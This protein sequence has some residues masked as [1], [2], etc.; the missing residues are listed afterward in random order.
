MIRRPG[1]AAVAAAAVTISIGRALLEVA[2]F[3]PQG[4]TSA[5]FSPHLPSLVG[6]AT[7]VTSSARAD[8]RVALHMILAQPAEDGI[9]TEDV[10][11]PEKNS[12]GIYH[13]LD[14]EQHQ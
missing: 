9:V 2:A 4:P 10:L 3:I 14:K 11:M 8:H 12:D 13:I 6:P 1:L 5:H 7:L